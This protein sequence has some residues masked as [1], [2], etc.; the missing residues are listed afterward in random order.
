MWQLPKVSGI[1]LAAGFSSCMGKDKMSLPFKGI[2]LLQHVVDAA[3]ASMLADITVVLPQDSDLE[4]LIDFTG[5]SIATSTE[6]HLG[7]LHSL[8]MGLE[9]VP[10]EMEGSMLLFGDQPLINASTLDMLI[11][12][13]QQQPEYWVVPVQE[14]MRGTP[15]IIPRC[16]FPEVAEQTGDLSVPALLSHPRTPVRLIRIHDIG[17]FIDIDD[18]QQYARLLKNH[19]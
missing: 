18:P 5:L 19:Q 15:I 14:D 6:R 2:P 8:H 12:A 1:I 4:S 10:A 9:R 17:P 16:H 7:A 3:R 11:G 13:F